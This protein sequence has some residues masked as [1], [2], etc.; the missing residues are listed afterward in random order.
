M[1]ASISPLKQERGRKRKQKSGAG[2]SRS[3][4]LT[5]GYK[6]SPLAMEG[7]LNKGR[8]VMSRDNSTYVTRDLTRPC[9]YQKEG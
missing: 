1:T 3:Y 8:A 2:N 4:S 5:E 9:L 7:V 6:P